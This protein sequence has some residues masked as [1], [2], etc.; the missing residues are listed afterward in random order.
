M[1]EELGRAAELSTAAGAL[2]LVYCELD[3]LDDA[4]R[5]AARAAE[6]GTEEDAITQMLWREARAMVLARRGEHEQAARLAREAIEIGETTEELTSKAEARAVL[7]E[8]L[9]IAGHTEE[10]ARALEE[11]LARFEA[12]ENLVRAAQMRERLASLGAE[13]D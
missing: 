5:W 7:G 4:E 13:V 11:A 10:A 3:R 6:L 9:A 8:I 1:R 12:K 2:A